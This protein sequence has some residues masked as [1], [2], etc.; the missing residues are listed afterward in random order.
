Q[1]VSCYAPEVLYTAALTTAVG[2]TDPGATRCP[3]ATTGEDVGP[4]A[5]QDVRNPPMLVKDHSESDLHVD[6]TN[7]RHLIGVSKW[8]VNAEGYNHLTGFYESFDGGASWPDRKSTRLN[9]SHLVI[10]YA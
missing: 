9:S 2:F 5:Q 8:F 7:E 6:P 10:S 4:Y 1:Q 3:G